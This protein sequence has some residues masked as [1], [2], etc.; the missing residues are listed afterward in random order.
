MS[1][2]LFSRSAKSDAALWLKLREKYQTKKLNRIHSWI[3][4]KRYNHLNY[5]NVASI[6]IHVKIGEG[7]NLPHGISGIFISTG[8]QI[9]KNCVIFHHV[10]LGTNATPNSKKLGAPIVGDN[11]FIGAGAVIVGGVTIGNN[12]LIG[13]NC[14]IAQ[15]IP[16]NCTVVSSGGI[17]IIPWEEMR[18]NSFHS[19]NELKFEELA[20]KDFYR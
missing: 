5:R 13:A 12:V 9:G 10:T 16:D 6:P 1:I 15:D 17:R 14:T 20:N 3:I 18:D 8:S 19:F 11:V 7:L 2:A 4:K